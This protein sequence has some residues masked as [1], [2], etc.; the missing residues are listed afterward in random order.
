[1][2]Q[3]STARI[4]RIAPMCQEM[5]HHKMMI[6]NCDHKGD[7]GKCYENPR[8]VK[9]SPITYICFYYHNCHKRSLTAATIFSSKQHTHRV[10]KRYA[11]S[12]LLQYL[13]AARGQDFRYLHI[14][15]LYNKEHTK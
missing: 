6:R 3:V 8:P 5:Y 13:P 14:C 9:K 7:T 2:P 15:I 11:S 1:M 4:S 12:L 10:I